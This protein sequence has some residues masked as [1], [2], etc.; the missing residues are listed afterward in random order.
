M[1]LGFLS[2]VTNWILSYRGLHKIDTQIIHKN[3]F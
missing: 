3:L 1:E 2:E